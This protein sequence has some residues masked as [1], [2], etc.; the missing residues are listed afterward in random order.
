[1]GSWEELAGLKQMIKQMIRK[2]WTKCGMGKIHKAE[3]QAK[4]LSECLTRGLLVLEAAE[5]DTMAGL[6]GDIEVLAHMEQA[7]LAGVMEA[8]LDD[9]FDVPSDADLDGSDS[10]EDGLDGED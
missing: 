6:E 4:A 10:K 7:S 3:F 5:E 8:C 2:G 1:M 9:Q